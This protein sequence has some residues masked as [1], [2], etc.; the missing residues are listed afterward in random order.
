[1]RDAYISILFQ[2]NDAQCLTVYLNLLVHIRAFIWPP[3]PLPQGES[4]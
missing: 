4:D 3:L 1:M 2:S